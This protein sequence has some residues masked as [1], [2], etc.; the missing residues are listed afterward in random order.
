[1]GIETRFKVGYWSKFDEIFQKNFSLLKYEVA[2]INRANSVEHAFDI[3]QKSKEII[4]AGSF[5]LKKWKS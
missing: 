4:S 3:Y 5:N 1:M 2:V